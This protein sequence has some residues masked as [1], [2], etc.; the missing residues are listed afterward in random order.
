M[1]RIIIN[2]DGTNKLTGRAVY[3]VWNSF[4]AFVDERPVIIGTVWF[5]VKSNRPYR[6]GCYINPAKVLRESGF[7]F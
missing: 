5:S 4:N 6:A 1:Y 7:I 2:R 3:R